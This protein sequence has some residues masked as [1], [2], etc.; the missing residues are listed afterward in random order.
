MVMSKELAFI[1]KRLNHCR[2]WPVVVSAGRVTSV[3]R[4]T[5]PDRRTFVRCRTLL[6]FGGGEQPPAGTGAERSAG[7]ETDRWSG[8]EAERRLETG[9][10]QRV[11]I[12]AEPPAASGADQYV[13]SGAERWSGTGAER[14]VGF[15]AGPGSHAGLDEH[16]PD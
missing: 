11:G 7:T 8:T 6:V 13:G 14:F 12:G 5:R 2:H 4:K 15:V 3:W 1:E 9:A 10:D 16:H